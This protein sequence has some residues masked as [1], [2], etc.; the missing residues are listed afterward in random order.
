MHPVAMPVAPYPSWEAAV[1]LVDG[2]QGTV[3]GGFREDERFQ[4]K[5]SPYSAPGPSVL[6]E[7]QDRDEPRRIDVEEQSTPGFYALDRCG[8]TWR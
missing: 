5:I 2:R 1:R 3:R 6:P 4:E 8:K 7:G